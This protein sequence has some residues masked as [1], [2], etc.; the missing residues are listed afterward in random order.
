[1]REIVAA[2]WWSCNGGS[3]EVSQ[4][5]TRRRARRVG[6]T[7]TAAHPQRPDHAA[8]IEHDTSDAIRVPRAEQAR[9]LERERELR[10]RVSKPPPATASQAQRA[11]AG[12][13][14]DDTCDRSRADRGATVSFRSRNAVNRFEDGDS[15]PG[16]EAIGPGARRDRRVDGEAGVGGGRKRR[17]PDTDTARAGP[18]PGLEQRDCSVRVEIT[19]WGPPLTGGRHAKCAKTRPAGVPHDTGA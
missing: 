2:G 19:G 13:I 16:G 17:A 14:L 7:H 18:D 6:L 5:D 10:R 12:E 4:G 1:M 9:P 15:R 11:D 8:L 3:R